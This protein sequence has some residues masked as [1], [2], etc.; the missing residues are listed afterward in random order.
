[1]RRAPVIDLSSPPAVEPDLRGRLGGRFVSV[2]DLAR[3]SEA[4]V[5]DR[6]R[7]RIERLIDDTDGEFARWMGARRSVSA[8]QALT[9]RAETRR[10]AEVDRLL[11]RLSHLEDHDRELVEQ[12]SH[13]LVAGLLHAPLAMLRDDQTGDRERAARELFS[14]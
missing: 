3:G 11:R 1:V 8:I 4:H 2:D 9:E 5:N 7:R 12:M 6:S 14:L 10:A 13:R